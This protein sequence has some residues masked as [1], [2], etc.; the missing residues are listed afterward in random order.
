MFTISW[1][2]LLNISCWN[3]ADYRLLF[4][5]K[6]CGINQAEDPIHVAWSSSPA[7]ERAH[8]FP[9]MIGCFRMAP[10]SDPTPKPLLAPEFWLILDLI[11]KHLNFEKICQATASKF[12]QETSRDHLLRVAS[13]CVSTLLATIPI[14][15][16]WAR[17]ARTGPC[18]SNTQV[19]L[20]CART[21][22]TQSVKIQEQLSVQ[23]VE[24]WHMAIH[25]C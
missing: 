17:R 5:K 23:D 15:A 3:H 1:S 13:R 2:S 6:I 14:V 18:Q 21:S 25:S 20:L 22:N 24:K 16:T 10:N 19:R 9:G 4:L 11:I 7:H 12:P 8:N